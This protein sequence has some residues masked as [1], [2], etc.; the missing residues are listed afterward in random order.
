M[1]R[2]TV[3]P[4]EVREFTA[5]VR[6]ASA[7]LPFPPRDLLR[8]CDKSPPTGLEVVCRE[9]GIW[10][11]GW[12]VLFLYNGPVRVR[13]EGEGLV[14]E[15][16]GGSYELPIPVARSARAEAARVVAEYARMAEEETRLAIAERNAPTWQNRLLTVVERHFALVTLGF[17]FVLV[18]ALVMLL[19]LLRGSFR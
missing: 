2:W 13:L 15:V 3:P 16:D 11:G 7:S 19:A 18:P 5:R 1:A 10:V 14:V 17:F 12:S 4:E 8:A 9:D 6:A